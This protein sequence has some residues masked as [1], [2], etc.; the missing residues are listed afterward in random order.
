MANKEAIVFIVDANLTMNA[1]YPPH[2]NDSV[3]NNGSKNE[4]SSLSN[5]RLSQAKDAV[6]TSIIDLMWRSKTHE[7]GV[8]V[9][10]AGITHHHLSEIER[11]TDDV[12]V[13]KFFRRCRGG[14][15]LERYEN[16][17]D[18]EEEDVFPNLVEFD[19][20]RP[21]PQTLRAI[22]HVQCT[23]NESIASSVQGDL[24]DGLILAADA[25][26]R[27]TNN[28][29]Y[30]RKIVMITDAEHEVEVNGEQL[31]CVLDG[32]NKMEVELIVIGIGFQENIVIPIK[33]G[34]EEDG[35]VN[36]K[37]LD[38]KKQEAIDIDS[39]D[40]DLDKKPEAV[41]SMK[42]EDN[43]NNGE[44]MMIKEEGN[45]DEMI[46]DN[47]S[48]KDIGQLIKRENE[49]LLAS[50]ARETKGCILAANGVNLT[51]LLQTKLPNMAGTKKSA[52][53]KIEF[54]IAPNLTLTVKSGKLTDKLNI[55]TTVKEAYQIHPETG[56][57][58][59]DGLGELMTLPTR[60]DTRHYLVEEDGN[61]VE[62]PFGEY[63][64]QVSVLC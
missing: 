3:K 56:K 32:L 28:K 20:N 33:D 34:E 35:S 9:L 60:T 58:L 47:D 41:V 31:Q 5:T 50:I 30:K 53:R 64:N 37:S 21:S 7:T 14:Y 62:V 6:L 44:E 36:D 4:S 48:K 38:D 57:K 46:L 22:N 17:D 12:D 61:E 49:K 1:P 39:D 45:P 11:I 25:L 18:E 63:V 51:E 29:K 26:H 40:D 15:K 2:S 55:P 10:K 52:P 23:I 24:C 27:R 13:G 54:R 42:E 19:L 43:D 16:D 59:R 8:V